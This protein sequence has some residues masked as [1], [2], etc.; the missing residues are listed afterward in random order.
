[1][2]AVAELAAN[3]TAME[4][5]RL[6]LQDVEADCV[7]TRESAADASAALQEQEAALAQAKAWADIDSAKAE[8]AETLARDTFGVTPPPP[9]TFRS[10]PSHSRPAAEAPALRPGLG[11]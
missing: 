6:R 10:P 11:S 7:E 8:A 2:Q 9:P 3:Q 1:V 5:M 4:G